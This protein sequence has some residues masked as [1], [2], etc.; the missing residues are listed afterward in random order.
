MNID[1]N[2]QYLQEK[3]EQLDD[4][5]SEIVVSIEEKIKSIRESA[6][7]KNYYILLSIISQI[8]SLLFLLLLFKN[9][10]KLI[11]LK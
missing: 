6:A 8:L 3:V 5:S 1:K 9:I 10:I 4:L 7:K 11:K 2:S